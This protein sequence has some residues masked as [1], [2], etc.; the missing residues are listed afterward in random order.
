MILGSQ[1]VKG[2]LDNE[3][4]ERLSSEE[5]MLHLLEQACSQIAQ[6]SQNSAAIISNSIANARAKNLEMNMKLEDGPT[7]IAAAVQTNASG[8]VVREEQD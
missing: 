2:D 7:A 8:P 6:S 3:R 4:K 1:G 5:S